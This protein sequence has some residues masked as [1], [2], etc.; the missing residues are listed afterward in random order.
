MKVSDKLKKEKSPQINRIALKKPDSQKKKLGFKVALRYRQ[1]KQTDKHT[2]KGQTGPASPPSSCRKFTSRGRACQPPHSN[3]L[4]SR[5]K[6]K[7]RLTMKPRL[8]S[9][10]KVRK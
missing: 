6:M 5:L 4:K 1:T 2:D 9:R 3:N 8:K 10:L 7:I